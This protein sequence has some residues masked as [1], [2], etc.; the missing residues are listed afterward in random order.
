MSGRKDYNFLTRT[1]TGIVFVA[2]V[3]T[4]MM[5]ERG[6]YWALLLLVWSYCSIEFMAL[7][8]SRGAKWAGVVYIFLCMVALG[9]FP[10]IGDGMSGEARLWSEGDGLAGLA[11][12]AGKWP[13]GWDPRMAPAFMVV[14]WANDVFAYLVGVA[15]GRHKMAPK[16]SPHKSWEGFAGGIVGATAVAAVVGRFWVGGEVWLWALFGVVVALA[17]VAGDLA[18]SRL[19][20]AAGVKDSGR[21]LPGHGGL[22]DRFD[23]TLGAVPV[24][25]VFLLVTHFLR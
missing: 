15:F 14:V 7:A 25:F 9:F 12:L 1:V 17:A 13:A 16:I 10:A 6:L 24:A 2:V 23:A 5:L 3:L 11:G 21:L 8:R 22:L 4:G 18:E 19:K 20:R